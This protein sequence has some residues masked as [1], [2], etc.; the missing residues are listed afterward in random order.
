[1]TFK[2]LATV[3]Q[4]AANGVNG[5]WE[6]FIRYAHDGTTLQCYYSS[7]NN[8]DDQDSMMKTS[9]DGGATWSA[10]KTIS[11]ADTLSRDGML[12]VA[13]IDNNGALIAVFENTETGIFTVDSVTSTDDGA[14][15]SAFHLLRWG[16]ADCVK[17][18]QPSTRLHTGER[19]TSWCSAGEFTFTR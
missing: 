19:Q 4:R 7:E 10:A 9:T 3:D 14:T 13:P 5:L 11:G 1:M 16:Q 15:V 18:G 2:Y 12:G 6:P 8:K 17:V